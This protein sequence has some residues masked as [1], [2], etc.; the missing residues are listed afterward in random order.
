MEGKRARKHCISRF[1]TPLTHIT[2]GLTKWGGLSASAQLKPEDSE[3]DSTWLSSMLQVQY[4]ARVLL[5]WFIRVRAILVAKID[6]LKADKIMSVTPF[7]AED[8]LPRTAWDWAKGQVRGFNR[9][10]SATDKVPPYMQ[11]LIRCVSELPTPA[12]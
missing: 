3:N 9:S 1:I 4:M 7:V 12:R 6:G 11:V 8:P 10:K 2:D 5:D